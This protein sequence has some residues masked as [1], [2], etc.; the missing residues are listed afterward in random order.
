MCGER[1]CR[2]RPERPWGRFIPACA[3]NAFSRPTPIRR[4]TV[5]PRVCGERF[6][7]YG[8]GAPGGGSSPRVRGTP[9]GSGP[10]YQSDRFIPACAGNAPRACPACSPGAVH[11]RVCGERRTS[12]P[13][14]LAEDGSSP[15]VRG[16][17]TEACLLLAVRRFIPAC[18]GNADH[19]RSQHIARAV[20]PRVCGERADGVGR[21]AVVSGSSPRVRGTHI[22]RQR[23]RAVDR[24]IPACAGNATRSAF[25]QSRRA[26][27]PRVCGE[28]YGGGAVF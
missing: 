9:S 14:R 4:S 13:D 27:H 24:F 21:F 2:W 22:R 28:R 17:L 6:G 8:V 1:A 23:E 10:T 7:G 16:T 20:H 12:D 26:V 3:G 18:A 5:H 11:P 25:Q 19:P 15:R